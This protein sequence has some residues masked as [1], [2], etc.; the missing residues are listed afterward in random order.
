MVV[1]VVLIGF[2]YKG[3]C[4]RVFLMMKEASLHGVLYEKLSIKIW[5]RFSKA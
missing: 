2:D 5:L 1:V 4:V 3:L